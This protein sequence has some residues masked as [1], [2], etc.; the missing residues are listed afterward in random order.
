MLQELRVCHVYMQLQTAS[1]IRVLIFHTC[2]DVTIVIDS[3]F[4]LHMSCM[5]IIGLAFWKSAH[6]RVYA[7][8]QDSEV[9]TQVMK[10]KMKAN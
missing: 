4:S 5:S 2:D 8:L 6:R 1:V 3:I 7:V 9:N 10:K